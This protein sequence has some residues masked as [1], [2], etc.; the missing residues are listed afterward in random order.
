M[1]FPLGAQSGKESFAARSAMETEMQ[2]EAM[3]S[4]PPGKRLKSVGGAFC[5]TKGI[6]VLKHYKL[7]HLAA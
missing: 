1:S 3:L 4:N 6:V 5:G 2:N 7:Q